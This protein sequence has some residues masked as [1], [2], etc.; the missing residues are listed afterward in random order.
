MAFHP[1]VHREFVLALRIL[2]AFGLPYAEVWR[3]LRPVA[4]RLGIPRP[5]YSSVRRIV[6]AERERKRRNADELDRLLADLLAGRFPYV[7]VE[8]KL[9]GLAPRGGA[10]LPAGDQ[11]PTARPGRTRRGGRTSPASLTPG[12]TGSASGRAPK[13]R[14]ERSRLGVP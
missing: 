13:E 6:I 8:H 14:R 10:E 3:M 11:P 2:D 4:A 9:V 12:L 1:P 5:S 7:F